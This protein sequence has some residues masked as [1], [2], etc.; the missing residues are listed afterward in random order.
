MVASAA[1]ASLLESLLSSPSSISSVPAV[2][3]AAPAAYW[4]SLVAGS[5]APTPPPMLREV[6]E[7][8]AAVAKKEAD[9]EEEEEESGGDEGETAV[10]SAAAASASTNNSSTVPSVESVAAFIASTTAELA[11]SGP[12]SSAA[13]AAS[14]PLDASLAA[15]GL[16][17]LAALKLRRSLAVRFGV[18]GAPVAAP[19]ATSASV[20]AAVVAAV[21]AK[22][23]G[24]GG[25]GAGKSPSKQPSSS[26]PSSSS[27]L[28]SLALPPSSSSSSLSPSSSW[29]VPTLKTPL[30]R[31]FCFPYAGGVSENVFAAWGRALP[32][33]V[34]VLPVELPGR[35]R[36]ASE[37]APAASSIRQFAEELVSG[38]ELHS[39]DA[40]PYALFGVC[41]G[42]IVAYEVARAA[43]K[44]G[45]RPPVALFVAA[46]SAPHLY[47]EAV[48]KLYVGGA[49]QNPV[50]APA[51]SSS[52][53]AAAA[54]SSSSSSSPASVGSNESTPSASP[55]IVAATAAL[56]GWR[57]LPKAT[58]LSVFK[59]GN[60]A[61]VDEMERNPRLFDRVAPVGVADILLAVGY[62]ASEETDENDGD[63]G[64]KGAVGGCAS[65]AGK[66]LR[67]RSGLPSGVK[68]LVAFEGI[69]DATI[70]AGAVGAWG[71][72]CGGGSGGDGGEGD[73]AL[74][75]PPSS[76]PPSSTLT[77][78][79]TASSPSPP[80]SRFELVS[81]DWDHYF[82]T[83]RMR[84][85]TD[86]VSRVLL[87]VV[88]GDDGDGE[89]KRGSGLLA[90][91]H[92]WV[93]GA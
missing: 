66:K 32:P 25:S 58:V 36:R 27:S 34:E 50:A 31:L 78:S 38:L 44:R 29:I 45:V 91:G 67:R 54:A 71:E 59:A 70:A 26:S 42:G 30:L 2:L 68:R 6:P 43:A 88:G 46:A 65:L 63:G 20:A 16:D 86:V 85:V 17:S 8:W 18:D 39:S 5:K 47:A 22:K 33:A 7:I 37:A 62:H 60:F 83:T 72:Y 11:D 48:A 19:G 92:S 3:G 90:E 57:S 24:S 14:I 51:Y 53:S 9:E 84:K 23:G 56:R 28:P 52:S 35:G 76:S 74:E 40:P 49:E 10:A 12:S 81:V 15:A 73:E 79:S 41:L 21:R 64:G 82:V 4:A 13:S 89:E 55:V 77:P 75:A 93:A 80:S 1:G 87:D 61:G 69:R